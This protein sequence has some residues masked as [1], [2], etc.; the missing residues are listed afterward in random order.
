M[1]KLMSLFMLVS[2]ISC[3]GARPYSQQNYNDR[4][5]SQPQRRA[6]QTSS[7]RGIHYVVKENDSLWKIANTYGVSVKEIMKRNR[8]YSPN[9]LRIG[10]KIFIPKRQQVSNS[11]FVWPIKGQIINFFG[12]TVNNHV[13]KG[14]NVRANHQSI[15]VLACADGRVV[16]A[17]SLKGWGKTI[18]IKHTSGLY[19]IYANL[20][21]TFVNEGSIAKK[22][23]T[24]GELASGKD[25]EYILHFEIR[26]KSTPYDPL[27]YLN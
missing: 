19:S 3:A 22:S 15:E 9:E 12:E 17:N 16:F 7:S 24:I 10:Q 1:I 21:T 5:Y 8:I 26:N 14:L 25:G 11:R 13:N 20:N 23:Q 18:I 27:R 2:I 4:S 6:R